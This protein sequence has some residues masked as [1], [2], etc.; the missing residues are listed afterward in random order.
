M[1]REFTQSKKVTLIVRTGFSAFFIALLIEIV[2]PGDLFKIF[3]QSDPIMIGIAV[4]LS[5]IIL[6]LRGFRWHVLIRN[7]SSVT[8]GYSLK[9]VVAGLTFGMF[10]PGRLGEISRLAFIKREERTK[11]FGLLLGEKIVE[12]ISYGMYSVYG[13]YL[14]FGAFIST[15]L[16]LFCGGISLFLLLNINY[17][18]WDGAVQ[19]VKVSWIVNALKAL[20]Q[21]DRRTT[22][23]V[24]G[25]CLIMNLLAFLQLFFLLNSLHTVALF[26]LAFMFPLTILINVIPFPTIAGIGPREAAAVYLFGQFGVPGEAA[27][28]ATFLWFFANTGIIGITGYSFWIKEH[29]RG[30][31]ESIAGDQSRK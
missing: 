26:P 15:G 16:A 25:I 23:S 31:E 8:Y 17:K 19:V 22:F 4:L 5:P 24:L 6:S 30:R 9:M 12:A 13:V 2:R 7:N 10:T 3:Q 28:A 20:A 21:F 11:A 29:S 27:F 14:I 1:W 18:L